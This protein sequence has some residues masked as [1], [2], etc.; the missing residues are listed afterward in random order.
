MNEYEKKIDGCTL[1]KSLF[2][3][4]IQNNTS[5][6]LSSIQNE[7]DYMKEN[8]KRL[9]RD[10][11]MADYQYEKLMEEIG[12]FESN[13]DD[14]HEI[15]L[16]LASFGESVTIA[17]TNIGYYNPSLIVFDGIVNGNPATLIQH[18]NQL[19]F[20]MIAVKK[21][22]PERPPHRIGF[23]VSNQNENQNE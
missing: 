13:L 17:V 6:I 14:E 18:V 9:S 2:D 10:Y 15:A 12:T 11:Y 19:S 23:D 8:F 1:D 21:S 16:K 4:I 20:L 3:E 22:E 7:S 5:S